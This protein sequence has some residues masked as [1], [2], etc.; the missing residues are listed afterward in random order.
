MNTCGAES[1]G[2]NQRKRARLRYATE[3]V[4]RKGDCEESPAAALGLAG[5]GARATQKACER[6][7][8][9]S[10]VFGA[11]CRRQ[12]PGSRMHTVR[13][14]EESWPPTFQSYPVEGE[15]E[16]QYLSL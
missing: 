11:L 5:I 6:A 15:A 8:P 3:G 16:R 12:Q 4:E 9:A 1:I 13:P 7:I 14:L 10:S 2:V